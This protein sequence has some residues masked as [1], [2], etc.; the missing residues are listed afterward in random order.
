[1]EMVDDGCQAVEDFDEDVTQEFQEDEAI[2]KLNAIAASDEETHE[3]V[4]D[5]ILFVLA[6]LF[7]SNSVCSM[8]RA[9][10][11]HTKKTSKNQA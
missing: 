3:T 6:L 10:C 1:M 11:S 5:Q 8:L 7:I 9:Y 4:S 2:R